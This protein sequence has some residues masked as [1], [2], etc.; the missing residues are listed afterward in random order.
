M[1]KYKLLALLLAFVMLPACT[2][3]DMSIVDQNGKTIHVASDGKDTYT[4]TYMC[5][6]MYRHTYFSQNQ[7]IVFDVLFIPLFSFPF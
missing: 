1:K 5:V 2:S 6:Y 3:Q 4:F 7:L